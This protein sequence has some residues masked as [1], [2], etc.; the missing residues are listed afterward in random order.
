MSTKVRIFRILI[1]SITAWLIFGYVLIPLKIQGISMEPAYADGGFRFCWQQ[2][3]LFRPLKRGD[4]VAIRFAGNRVVL[5]KRVIALAGDSVEFRN[6]DLIL[7]GNHIQE[8]YV[9]YN[10]HWNLPPRTVSPGKVYVVGDNRGMPMETHHFGQVNRKRI[11]GGV[12]W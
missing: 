12:L 6:G 3:Y 11:V 9:K 8:P 7:N 1:I 4:V 10:A 2:S 5:L